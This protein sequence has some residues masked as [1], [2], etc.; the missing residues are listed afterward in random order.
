MGLDGAGAPGGRIKRLE[1]VDGDGIYDEAVIFMDQISWPNGIYPWE[2][3]L[4]IS[5][6]PHVFFASD[7]DGDGKADLVRRLFEGFGVWNQ[8][9]LVNGFV[10]G[11]DHL[12]HGANGDS[13][14]V[15]RSLWSEDEWNIR[16]RDF[17]FNPVDGLFE[18]V[19]GQTQFGRRR[20]DWGNWYGNN[21]PPD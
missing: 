6:A 15:V 3:G 1:D 9:H 12:L 7:S 11:L 2:N 19:E 17:R 16:R 13:S 21:N 5:A 4:W 20:D 18:M 14:G 8:Q 10:Y